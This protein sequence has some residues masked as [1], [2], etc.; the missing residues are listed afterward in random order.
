MTAPKYVR[1]T[2][3]RMRTAYDLA[4]SWRVVGEQYGLPKITVY[5]IACRG[6]EPK[7][8][9]IRARLGWPEHVSSV[10]VIRGQVEP[11]S[12]TV[13]SATCRLCGAAYIPNVHNRGCCYLCCPPGDRR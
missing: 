5:R 9:A 2:A 1:E 6:Y 12:Q 13:G 10:I 7:S 11:G 3:A 8:P 4:R